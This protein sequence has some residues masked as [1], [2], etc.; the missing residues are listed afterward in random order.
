MPILSS[1]E[2][3]ISEKIGTAKG[4]KLCLSRMWPTIVHYDFIR[5]CN[6]F[7]MPYYIFQGRLDNNTPSALIQDYYDAIKAPDKD[8]VWFE[9]SAHG[10]MGEEPE[11]FKKL[12]REKFLKIA[13]EAEK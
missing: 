6:E 8:L 4:Y 10:P 1:P 7:E 5:D 13:Q 3:S 11:K 12:M 9:N 2:L